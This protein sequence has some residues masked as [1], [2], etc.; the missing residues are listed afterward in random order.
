MEINLYCE[1][2]VHLALSEEMGVA[3]NVTQ[4]LHLPLSVCKTLQF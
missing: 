2:K 3:F 1:L 4:L